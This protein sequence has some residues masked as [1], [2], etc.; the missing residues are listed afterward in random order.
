MA[1]LI[2]TWHELAGWAGVLVAGLALIGVGRLL[3]GGRVAPEAALV[4]GWGGAAFLLTLWGVLTPLSLRLPAVAVLALGGLGLALPRLR[5]SGAD[6]R[7]MMRVAVLALPLLAVLASARPSLP[8]T[9]LNLRPNAA[10]LYDHA[11]FPADDRPPAHS[12]LPGAPY[13]MQLAALL[14]SLVT[15]SF[16]ESAMIGL[17]L[18]LQVAFGLF[19]ARL[20]AGGEEEPRAAP[21]WGAAALGLLLAT[22]LNPGFVPR[23]H[24]SAYSETSVTVTVAF[25]AW[26]GARALD[27]T[28]AGRGAGHAFWMLA[29]VLA[30]LV[31]IKQESV[32]LAAGVLATGGALALIAPRRGATMRA[33]Y[34]IVLAALP[35]LLLYLAWRWYVLS[36]FAVGE[37]KPLPM[38]EWKFGSLPSILWHML[39]AIGQKLFLFGTLAATFAGL[40]WHLR[41]RGLDLAARLGALLA[42]VFVVYNAALVFA[43]VAHF[44]GTVGT[45]AHSY[46][47]Y[48]THLSLLL[49]MVV[50]MLARDPAA[51]WSRMLPP[52]WW[53]ALPAAGIVAMLASPIVFIGYLRFDLEVPALRAW[54]LAKAAAP[55]IGP[56][57]RLALLLPGDNASVS[58]MLEGVLRYTPPRRP[59]I[60]IDALP[61]VGP[62]TLGE[63]TGG[64]LAL[65]SCMPAGLRGD[66]PA[67]PAGSAALLARDGS[68]WRMVATWPYPVPPRGARWSHVLADEALCL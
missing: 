2:P 14:A 30:A 19:L 44:P 51:R 13:N 64:D 27:R 53:R 52:A 17:N 10:Y 56:S 9:W 32:A 26:F 41:S 62:A 7:G 60:A 61:A 28:A 58:A 36:H 31:N 34:G 59:G 33:L 57:D 42:G 5:P 15:P 22:A 24:M 21:G 48:N 67:V 18:L 39:R 49:V 46:F 43:Y 1:L 47:R 25:A 6:W 4:A 11:S 45:E 29:L 68:G 38:T 50:V 66:L 54:D 3:S 8:D 20:A 35:A 65:L 63:L 40:A 23:Y 16:P 12:F 55:H 37:L